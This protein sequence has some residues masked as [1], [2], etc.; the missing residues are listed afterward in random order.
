[1]APTRRDESISVCGLIIDVRVL[2]NKKGRK[3]ALVTLD[4]KTGRLDVRFFPEQFDM[5]QESLQ[6]DKI[7]TVSGQVSFDS[8]SDGNTMTGRDVMSLTQ[9][10]EKFAKCIKLKVNSAEKGSK[11]RQTLKK[12]LLPFKDGMTP[13][14]IAYENDIA[15]ADLE[16]GT[17]WRVSPD[18]QLF[19]D[20]TESLEIKPELEF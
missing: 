3:W 5:F 13:I 11:L 1:V 17:S 9:A 15:T 4:D 14:R 20:I 8:F 2:I 19:M 6:K 18:D 12:V 10:R 16:L 7:I